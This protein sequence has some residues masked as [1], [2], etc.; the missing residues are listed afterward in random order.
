MQSLASPTPAWA[1][2]SQNALWCYHLLS[3]RPAAVADSYTIV[4]MGAELI[5]CA[6]CGSQV[7][8]L[9][10][11]CPRCN[12]ICCLGVVCA[13]CRASLAPN[14]AVT[15]SCEAYPHTIKRPGQRFGDLAYHRACLEKLDQPRRPWL[16][17][18]ATCRSQ[19]STQGLNVGL[20]KACSECGDPN[21]A[22]GH[23]RG[24]AGRNYFLTGC[25]LCHIDMVAGIVQFYSYC[26]AEKKNY[27]REYGPEYDIHRAYHQYCFE[28]HRPKLDLH[29]TEATALAI[30]RPLDIGYERVLVAETAPPMNR[31]KS[32]WS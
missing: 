23:P 22:Y 27:G 12:T 18:C 5:G 20:E 32:F 1:F 26:S 13:I 31:K 11:K 15:S 6:N 25:S 4:G 9:A 2:L 14:E 10:E 8:R 3:F 17:K 19:L 24:S 21:P 30:F 16:M 7:S 28:L 29:L